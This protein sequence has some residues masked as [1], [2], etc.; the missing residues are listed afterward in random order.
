[1]GI[2][3]ATQIKTAQQ[4]VEAIRR[5]WSARS[6][7]ELRSFL[8][9]LQTE[10]DFYRLIRLTDQADL[11]T[12]SHLLA[13]QAHKRF[14][15]LRTFTWQCARLLETGRSLEAEER[16][17]GRLQGIS[18]GNDSAE[19][20]ASAHQLLLRVYA[21]LNRLPEAKA[22]LT[23][24]EELK[25]FVWPDLY[26][27]YFIHSGEWLE[28]ERVL[29]RELTDTV[30]ERS[31]YVRL[32]YADVLAMTGR[33]KES[34]AVLEK[35][36][37]LEPDNWTFRAD[38]V[39]TSF[40]L[41]HYEKTLDGI[42]K[43]NEKNPYHVF[44]PAWIH[45]TAECLYKLE[46]WEELE[47]WVSKHPKQLG[48]T[49]YGKGEIRQDATRRELRLTPNIQKLNYCVPASLA[50]MLEAYGMK[51]GQDEIAEHVFDVTGSD[52]QKTMEYMESLG[53]TARYFKGTVD[54]YKQVIDA[55]VPVLLS[56]MIENS[57]H[58][59]VVIGYD[60]R[61]QAL[62]IQ[63]PNDL[64]PFLLSYKDV[65]DTYKLSDSLSMLFVTDEQKELLSLL[66]RSEHEFFKELF[67]IWSLDDKTK[68]KTQAVD[69]LKVHPDERYGAVVGLVTQFSEE[70]KALHSAWLDKLH[71]D[72]GAEDGEVA[73]LAAHM[74]YQKEEPEQALENL[75][76]VKEKSSPYA[77]FLKA[78]ILMSRSE[79][80]K[81]VPLLKRSI[82]LDHYQ[83]MAYSHLARCYLEIGKIYQAFK[84]SS[85]ALEQ[86][87]SDV[88]ARITHSLIQFE[89][90][91]Y[92]KALARFRELS[93]EQPEDGY[94]IYEA[95]RCLLA[96]GEETEAIAAFERAR[97]ID[98]TEPYAYL[99]IAEIHLEAKA[100]PQAEEIIRSGIDNCGTADVL[101]QYLGHIAMEQEQYEQA[102]AEYRKSLQLDPSDLFTVTHIA[103]ALLK[104]KRVEETGRLLEQYAEAGDT[105]YFVRTAAL[106]WQ[107][108]LDD[109]G[110]A[111]ALDLL[112]NGMSREALDLYE[113][114]EQYAE[115]A[116]A[117]QFRARL[118]DFFKELRAKAAD[119]LLLCY[120]AGVYELEDHHRFARI[121]YSRAADI[122]G[123]Y[124]AHYHLGLLAEQSENWDKALLHYT[125]S[126]EK[127][128]GFTAA[129]EGLMRTYLA[130]E[131][132]PKAFTAALHVLENEPL[133]LDL[134]ELFELVDTRTQMDAVAGVLQRVS[135]QVP[136]EWLLS[137]EAHMAE[138][139]GDAAE[140]ESL[141][142]RAQA[143]NGALPSR[144]QHM[145][146]CVRQGDRKRAIGML[147]D[148]I[149]E[150]PDEEGF[151]EEYVR[152]L[153]E[154]RKTNDLH[155][156]LKKRLRGE[157]LAM[158]ET[159]SADQLVELADAEDGEQKGFFRRLREKS[160]SIIMFSNTIALYRDAAKNFKDSEVPVL[161]LAEFYMN[162]GMAEEAVR[163]LAP[164]VKQTGHFGAAKML[165][166]ATLQSAN[167]KQSEKLLKKAISMA[168]DL[169]KKQPADF[170]ILLWLGDMVA[171]QEE[172]E[173][174]EA[175]YEQA[176][177]SNPYH[178]ES[179]V[180]LMNLLA[181]HRPDKAKRFE[182]RLPEELLVNE[183]IRLSLAM[184]DITLGDSDAATARLLALQADEP[185]YLP[186]DYE[187]ARAAMK[188]GQVPRA[189]E[190][191]SNL[192]NKDG[193]ELFIES[194]V[195]EELFEEILEEVLAVGV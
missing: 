133:P 183:W 49:V 24:Y 75:A 195:E 35:G 1:M 177:A 190:L 38:M 53:F 193:G 117:P 101:H 92:E 140:A 122:N 179:Y 144:Y 116:E 10:E 129:H 173:Q 162:R 88:Y 131:D 83:P 80:Q 170:E 109:A 74:H 184:M 166:Q 39:R 171:I 125:K 142:L 73:L 148:L 7:R 27:Y 86:E 159:Y 87:P 30:T 78:A 67:A 18:A 25:G 90:G 160:R 50:L 188:A 54:L 43:Y 95:G 13:T 130:L 180:H 152:L 150:H 102:E 96:L 48:K 100:W 132:K 28:A 59:Q 47:A 15:T 119:P 69:F 12:Y 94:F 111:L 155:K 2:M 9:E 36:Q 163:A 55:G 51:K 181:E 8:G 20:L 139:K 161:H 192:F 71:Q 89:S 138:K 105:D 61:L 127:D 93:A 158:A 56:M 58:V 169:Q 64:G 172:V 98:S 40:F 186:A 167:N 141:F 45:I 44:R 164:F 19:E 31:D 41:G 70:A 153:A 3:K 143:V 62:I 185:D 52:L 121:L 114:A 4:A 187:L 149:A 16:M 154:M 110:K 29:E 68:E 191:L 134:V 11:Y 57:A 42:A 124:L 145:Q 136:E 126:A 194:A 106:L 17:V 26:G 107:E 66:D 82:E 189:K 120:E 168:E 182:S 135:L 76:R 151:Y 81:A 104:Q 60:D 137:A 85:I 165:L 108:S 112:E 174:A 6:T 178:S 33:Q 147:E 146:F 113:M 23:R 46:R 157:K 128:A 118:L 32:L 14:G 22:Q 37:E 84:W 21:Q 103:H 176:I 72:L 115:F 99:R 156:R 97:E 34:L 91:A 77:L 5:L 63:D 65:A 123:L 79:H 175:Y